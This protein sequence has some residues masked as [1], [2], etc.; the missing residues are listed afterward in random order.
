VYFKQ[1]YN[2][3]FRE[4][5]PHRDG[6]V[7]EL[8]EDVFAD[9]LGTIDRLVARIL[10]GAKEVALDFSGWRLRELDRWEWIADDCAFVGCLIEQGVF[11]VL[12]YQRPLLKNRQ[13]LQI[14]PIP[15]S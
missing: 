2:C 7:L 1:R 3:Y 10:P 13:R 4:I 5:G 9:Y 8:Q 15:G 6:I 14:G 11:V 12:D